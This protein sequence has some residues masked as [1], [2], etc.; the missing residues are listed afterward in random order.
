PDMFARKEYKNVFESFTATDMSEPTREVLTAM[1]G[2]IALQL[3]TDIAADRG[4][5]PEALQALIDRGL[6]LDKEA[7]SAGLVDALD[8][9]YHL[10]ERIKKD[11][12]GDPESTK[13]KF[14]GLSHYVRN[15]K[16][17]GSRSAGNAKVALIYAQGAIVPQV[18]TASMPGVFMG[19][20]AISAVEMS[21][22]LYDAME[23]DDIE[24][25]VIRIN[26]PGGSPA[27]S[28]TLRAR[29]LQAQEK[30]KKVIVSMGDAAASGGYW[31][32]A[33]A[34]RIFAT[35]LTLTGSIGVAGGKFVLA[36]MWAK[37]GVNWDGVEWGD[38]AGMMSSNALY[39]E[40]ERARYGA[41]MDNVYDGFVAR[42]AEGRKMDPVKAESLAHGRVWT[43]NQA[44]A[45]GLVDEIG[46]LDQAL[47]YAAAQVGAKDRH[48]IAL[49]ILPEPETAWERL[50][51]FLEMQSGI[52]QWFG[53]VMGVAHVATHGDDFM[54]YEPVRVR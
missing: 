17:A 1:V 48:A 49:K 46:G 18:N 3:R 7:Q 21:E 12:T 44:Q 10:T 11:V 22:T 53:K 38:N 14:V 9:V 8:Y 51:E 40:T 25:I 54:V 43:G 47:D 39:S 33:P 13:L 35:P 28:E 24:V 42:V 34:D 32:V 50:A 19:G 2:D 26:S 5:T 30:G 27:A 29:I 16:P 45:R 4:M 20:P 37:I 6:L 52:G 23:D 36:D 15:H 31:M 41:M